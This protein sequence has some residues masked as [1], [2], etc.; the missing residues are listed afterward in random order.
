MEELFNELQRR[1]AEGMPGLSLTDED[2]GQLEALQAEE[3]AYP[4]TFPCVLIGMP[5]TDWENLDAN[6]QKGTCTIT[7]RLAMDCYDDTHYGSTTEG[8]AADRARTA[9][10]LHRLLQGWRPAGMLGALTRKKS[11][12]YSRPG[13]IKV[14]ETRYEAVVKG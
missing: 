5:E 2:Y 1:I 3:D 11:M 10:R 4:V 13:G 14:Y 8:R 9:T 6:I 7:V 12:A